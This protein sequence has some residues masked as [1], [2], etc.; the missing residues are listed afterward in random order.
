MIRMMLPA[1]TAA[2]VIWLFRHK[3]ISRV[4][5]FVLMT[6]TLMTGALVFQEIQK[7]D[8]E[9]I[10]SVRRQGGDQS[11]GQVELAVDDVQGGKKKITLEI[12]EKQ[13]ASREARA[14]LTEEMQ[15]LDAVILGKNQG[16]DRVEWNLQLPDT[17]DNPLVS[18]SW[19]TDRPDLVG[20]DGVLSD[21]ISE[22]GAQV[23]LTGILRLSDTEEEYQRVMTVF[24]S[25]EERAWQER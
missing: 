5:F 3:K 25:R 15:N 11:A 7:G 17:L 21:G 19:S 14:I 20:W 23:T 6:G 2:V 13:Y 18:V 1:A 22:G 12:P 24:P 10:Q 8:W 16:F 9:E 4:F